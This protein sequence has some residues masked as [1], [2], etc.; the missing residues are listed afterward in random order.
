MLLTLTYGLKKYSL[1][2]LPGFPFNSIL[3]NQ[4]K[5]NILWKVTPVSDI[6]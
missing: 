4:H 6:L 5:I 1:Y 3:T 2:V